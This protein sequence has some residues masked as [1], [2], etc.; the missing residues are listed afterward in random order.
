MKNSLALGITF[1][2]LICTVS[3][4]N[5]GENDIY[6]NFSYLIV[7]FPIPYFTKQVCDNKFIPYDYILFSKD[8]C[9]GGLKIIHAEY[10]ND[11]PKEN[12]T[13]IEYKN[14][15]SSKTLYFNNN[16]LLK[17]ISF[18]Y[19]DISNNCWI[20]NNITISSFM[21]YTNLGRRFEIHI[22]SLQ[23]T[24]ESKNSRICPLTL[25]FGNRKQNITCVYT[26]DDV[27]K[28]E[29][30]RLA[31]NK[32]GFIDCRRFA[33]E[34]YKTLG[35]S[36]MIENEEFITLIS[37]NR[38]LDNFYYYY[39]KNNINDTILRFCSNESHVDLSNLD[40]PHLYFFPKDLNKHD[41]FEQIIFLSD[42]RELSVKWDI[43]YNYNSTI[44][45]N[46]SFFQTIYPVDIT[47]ESESGDIYNPIILYYH[48]GRLLNETFVNIT[49]FRFNKNLE[50]KGKHFK[51]FEKF[52]FPFDV[53]QTDFLLDHFPIPKNSTSKID[54]YHDS[55]IYSIDEIMFIEMA[56]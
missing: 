24:T 7:P 4:V 35:N 11:T 9:L 23:G 41:L 43:V 6:I 18:C 51:N 5:W 40:G 25:N 17:N 12:F 44:I 33:S 55:K 10:F 47:F 14:N 28:I 52:V 26:K 30:F 36:I 3:G 15:P 46:P 34:G 8:K 22:F 53:Y 29:I 38:N 16:V 21:S 45:F 20:N 37:Y 31:P 49:K 19:F 54:S 50:F 13:F 56:R 32:T 39:D 42:F 1:L 2:F 27:S 48:E